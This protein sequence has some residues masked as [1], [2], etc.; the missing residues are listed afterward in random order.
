MVNLTR[1]VRRIVGGAAI[2]IALVSIVT[3][4]L[5]Q[6]QTLAGDKPADFTT[7]D[8]CGYFYGSQTAENSSVTTN[9]GTTYSSSRGTWT[10][11]FNNYVNTRVES[12]GVVQG[13]FSDSHSV[14]SAG[15]VSGTEHFVSNA[16]KIDQNYSFSLLTGWS[17]SVT[18]TRD[19]SFL[20]SD[21]NGHCYTG[22]FPRP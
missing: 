8:A 4:S 14:D 16:G 1:K 6:S 21:T 13:A 22:P 17:V 3:A 9:G 5:L 7:L 19:L 18:A 2:S 11:V 10:G 15:N 12:L 20:T